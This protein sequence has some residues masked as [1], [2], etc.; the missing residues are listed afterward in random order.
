[1]S[2]LSLASDVKEEEGGGSYENC[3]MLKH[4]DCNS[5]QSSLAVSFSFLLFYKHLQSFA[6]AHKVTRVRTLTHNAQNCR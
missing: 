1:M 2:A 4:S 6:A 3:S 5:A